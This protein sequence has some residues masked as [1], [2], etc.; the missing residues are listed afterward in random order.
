MGYGGAAPPKGDRPH[1]YYFVVH[2]VDVEKL[3]VNKD[4]SPAAVSF[5]LAGHTLARAILTPTYKS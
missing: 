1:R 2:A 4:A 3:G 5:H